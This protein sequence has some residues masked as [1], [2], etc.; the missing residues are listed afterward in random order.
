MRDR[1]SSFYGA[2]SAKRIDIAAD[3]GK[4]EDSRDFFMRQKRRD[5]HGLLA[6][7]NPKSRSTIKDGL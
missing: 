5:P 2:T 4:N 6:F 1:V 7:D 3:V